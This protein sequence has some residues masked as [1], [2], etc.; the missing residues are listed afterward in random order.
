MLRVFTPSAD[1]MHTAGLRGEMCVAAWGILDGHSLPDHEGYG[2]FAK[3][4]IDGMQSMS[5]TYFGTNI[6]K[7]TANVDTEL[8]QGVSLSQA[9]VGIGT[10]ID[11]S[12][13]DCPPVGPMGCTEPGG[14]CYDWSETKLRS[15][16][17]SLAERGVTTLTLWRADIDA[18][19]ECTEP[20]FFDVAE[21]FLAGSHV[22]HS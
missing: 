18:E 17:S 6:T 8:Q 10:Q 22:P 4:G 1:A 15:F 2:V 5:S 21:E 16:V 14:Q 7:N 12:L 20:Y 13:A 11:P 9:A 3:S 19:G